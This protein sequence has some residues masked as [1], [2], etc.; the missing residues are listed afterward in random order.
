MRVALKHMPN[1]QIPAGPPAPTPLP[2][3][4]P[5]ATPPMAPAS[6]VEGAPNPG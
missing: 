3:A 2:M 4:V 5:A 6:P 1:Q